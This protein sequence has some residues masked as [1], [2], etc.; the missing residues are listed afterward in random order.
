[1]RQTETRQQV[2]EQRRHESSV[3]ATAGKESRP[4]QEREPKVRS[5]LSNKLNVRGSGVIAKE[6][7]WRLG[8]Q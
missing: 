4:F 6:V 2:S 1:M 3:P 5:Q 8:D 7:G